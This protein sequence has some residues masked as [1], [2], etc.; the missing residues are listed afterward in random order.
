MFDMI[1]SL[2][3][4]LLKNSPMDFV[5]TYFDNTVLSGVS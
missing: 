4:F 3:R 2:W 1:K 5:S